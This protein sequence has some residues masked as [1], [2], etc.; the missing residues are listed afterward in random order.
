[1]PME[2][3]DDLKLEL[4]DRIYAISFQNNPSQE[5]AAEILAIEHI[6]KEHTNE[7]KYV[8]NNL[9][10]EEYHEYKDVFSKDE[11]DVLPPQKPWDHA[12]DLV[13]RVELPHAQTFPI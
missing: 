12:I 6:T 7:L 8:S 10:P 11:F 5:T 9:I 1:M 3:P 2:A 4:G 13:P